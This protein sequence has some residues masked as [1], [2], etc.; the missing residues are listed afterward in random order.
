MVPSYYEFEVQTTEFSDESSLLQGVSGPYVD[1]FFSSSRDNQI[2]YSSWNQ[3]PT[4]D[5]PNGLYKFVSFSV[6]RDLDKK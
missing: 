2:T 1:D 6:S 5:N 3:F 4:E